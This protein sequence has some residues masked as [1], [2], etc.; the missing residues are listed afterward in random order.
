MNGYFENVPIQVTW[1]DT[2]HMCKAVESV[3]L[4][5]KK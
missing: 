5:P 1:R 2:S 3:M 4:R